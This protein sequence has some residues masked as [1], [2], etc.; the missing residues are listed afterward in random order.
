MNTYQKKITSIEGLIFPFEE[1]R[2]GQYRFMGA[3]YQTLMKKDILY[4]TAPTGI[5]KTV[6][7]NGSSPFCS[8]RMSA[9]CKV[10]NTSGNALVSSLPMP[11]Y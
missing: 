1:Y 2:E 5:G 11:T 9:F 7:D 3:V 10:S 4:S 6:F 8:N